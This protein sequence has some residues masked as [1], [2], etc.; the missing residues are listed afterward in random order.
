MPEL[1][2]EDPTLPPEHAFNKRARAMKTDLPSSGVTARALE[3]HPLPESRATEPNP[4]SGSPQAPL[5]GATPEQ[6]TDTAEASPSAVR[7]HEVWL[8]LLLTEINEELP[9][10]LIVL[11]Q[12]KE[13]VAK[14]KVDKV[15]T[16]RLLATHRRLR[17][18]VRRKR[19]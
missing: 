18:P 1:D 19:V 5:H 3:T 17:E 10:A 6:P 2:D 4:S 13:R 9:E 15:A 7:Q 16:E 8:T 14:L 11:Q 12:A